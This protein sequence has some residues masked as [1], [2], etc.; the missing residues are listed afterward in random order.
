M[1]QF[2]SKVPDHGI[3]DLNFRFV[4]YFETFAR[5]KL[6][7]YSVYPIP[8]H[9]LVSSVSLLR[10]TRVPL[11]INEHSRLAVA[12]SD[13]SDGIHHTRDMLGGCQ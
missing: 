13:L 1:H 4:R 11:A 12:P 10:L 2:H 8:R 9:N 7:L 6:E 3:V 5:S